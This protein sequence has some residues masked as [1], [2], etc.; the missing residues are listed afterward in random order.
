MGTFTAISDLGATLGPAA[1]GIIIHATGYPIMFASLALVGTVN[2]NYF[3][4][5]VRRRKGGVE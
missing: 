1:M 3:C 4:F 5:F 2:L